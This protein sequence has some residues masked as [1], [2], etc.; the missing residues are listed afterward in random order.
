MGQN[1]TTQIQELFPSFLEELKKDECTGTLLS[2]EIR[3]LSHEQFMNYI[4]ELNVLSKKYE[5]SN[6]KRLVFAVKQNTDTSIFWKAT[7]Q[8][9]CVKL[10]AKCSQVESFRLMNLPEFIKVFKTLKCQYLTETESKKLQENLEASTLFSNIEEAMKHNKN[11]ANLENLNECCICLERVPETLLP[12][13][14]SYC[15][16]CIEEWSDN[17]DTCPICREKLKSS[18]DTWVLSEVPKAEEISEEIRSNLMSLTEDRPSS[19]FSS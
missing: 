7:V 18:D 17:H 13:T 19:C 10:D 16:K 5:D 8:I 9:A 4:G 6:G 15:S 14:H 12:C 3:N 2:A 1:V 11:R